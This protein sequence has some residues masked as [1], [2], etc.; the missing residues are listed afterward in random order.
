MENKFNTGGCWF[1]CLLWVLWV[2]VFCRGAWVAGDRCWE[3]TAT[4]KPNE[5][6]AVV[7]YNMHTYIT[8]DVHTVA[9]ASWCS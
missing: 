6:T 2:W 5:R 9:S 7:L 4:K 1:G 8:I 3:K